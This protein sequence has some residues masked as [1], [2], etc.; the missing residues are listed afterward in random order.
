M[1]QE[2]DDDRS[3]TQEGQNSR[4]HNHSK[5]DRKNASYVARN[6]QDVSVE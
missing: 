6:F 4:A 5:D 2:A 1:E 3:D